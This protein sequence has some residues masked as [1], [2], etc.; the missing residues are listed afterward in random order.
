MFFRN[1]SGSNSRPRPLDVGAVLAERRDARVDGVGHVHE[2]SRHAD[3]GHVGVPDAGARRTCLGEYPL[4]GGVPAGVQGGEPDGPVV[5]VIDRAF[6]APGEVEV[7]RDDHLGLQPAER[8]RQVVSQRDPVLDQPVCMIEELDLG[9][10]DDCGAAALFLHPQR[11]N[12]VGRHAGDTC[13]TP[14]REQVGHVFP[15]AGPPGHGGGDAIFEII[16]VSHH[17]HGPVPV[18]R[19][20]LHPQHPFPRRCC[21]NSLTPRLAVAAP[22]PAVHHVSGVARR[23]GCRA[24]ALYW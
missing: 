10:P 5:G 7:H 20:R 23:G 9:Y 21:R 24:T 19:H 15:L 17:G 3:C 11:A 4:V 22:L 1:S 13:L 8:G 16:R 14:G 12:L 2:V 18:L 6:L